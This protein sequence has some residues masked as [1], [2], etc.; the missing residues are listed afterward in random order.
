MGFNKYNPYLKRLEYSGI[1][2]SN[3]EPI[4]EKINDNLIVI[5][6]GDLADRRIKLYRIR[7]R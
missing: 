7:E 3:I 6:S 2:P 5:L 1:P 4:V